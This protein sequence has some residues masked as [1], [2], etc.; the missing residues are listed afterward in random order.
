VVGKGRESRER[1]GGRKKNLRRVLSPRPRTPVILPGGTGRVRDGACGH[2]NQRTL[3]KSGED[4]GEA[5]TR[6]Q[7]ACNRGVFLKKKT[8]D[9]TVQESQ[10]LSN[11]I[12]GHCEQ[13]SASHYPRGRLG[14]CRNGVYLMHSRVAPVTRFTSQWTDKIQTGASEFE[15]G[16]LT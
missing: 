8:P 1:R 4:W 6:R 2:V 10:V 14:E 7:T 13:Q 16:W 12:D 9:K 5:T 3:T 15:N 11:G